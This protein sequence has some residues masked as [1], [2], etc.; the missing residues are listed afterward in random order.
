MVAYLV[1][2]TLTNKEVYYVMKVSIFVLIVEALLRK[3]CYPLSKIN[4]MHSLWIGIST[5]FHPKNEQADCLVCVLAHGHLALDIGHD[6]IIL[7]V[8]N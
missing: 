7:R 3:V 4:R 8:N 2:K 5:I 6:N 1:P